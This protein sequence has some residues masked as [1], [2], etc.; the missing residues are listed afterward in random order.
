MTTEPL[1]DHAFRRDLHNL[2]T[3]NG[4]APARASQIVDLACHAA[5][6]AIF[7]FAEVCKAAPDLGI[8]A[9]A[10]EIGLQL[11]ATHMAEKA[12]ELH[13]FG[14]RMGVPQRA[15]NFEVSR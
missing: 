12:R 8:R 6:A 14:K 13:G 7:R 1:F 3:G 5:E 15:G 11:A 4:A 10:T 9:S 2:L